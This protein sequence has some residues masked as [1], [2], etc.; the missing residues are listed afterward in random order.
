MF[1]PPTLRCR[2]MSSRGAR[3]SRPA[4]NPPGKLLER[5]RRQ[6]CSGWFVVQPQTHQGHRLYDAQSIA[7]TPAEKLGISRRQQKSGTGK[8]LGRCNQSLQVAVAFRH[9][10]AKKS[11]DRRA[12]GQPSIPLDQRRRSKS[13]GIGHFVGP[14]VSM[15]SAAKSVAGIEVGPGRLSYG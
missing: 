5:N 11:D 4:R 9:G 7:K 1:L 14:V 13:N 15:N 3:R 10:E 12:A 6:E 8:H 2:W